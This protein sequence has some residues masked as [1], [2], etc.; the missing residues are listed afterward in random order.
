MVSFVK[1]Y[2]KLLKHRH[3]SFDKSHFQGI[4]NS[5]FT[6]SDKIEIKDIEDEFQPKKMKAKF[7]ERCFISA[8]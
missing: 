4:V 2:K 7:L 1:E 5:T 6:F 8:K 3:A